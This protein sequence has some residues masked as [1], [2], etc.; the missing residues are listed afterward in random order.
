[1]PQ[2]RKEEYIVDY[3]FPDMGISIAT[4]GAKNHN[5]NHRECDRKRYLIPGRHGS[6][7]MRFYGTTIHHQ[8]ANCAY[9]VRK[10]VEARRMQAMARA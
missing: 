9:I 2:Y 6:T 10:E 3:V 7:M 1:M 5:W 8:A 4:D